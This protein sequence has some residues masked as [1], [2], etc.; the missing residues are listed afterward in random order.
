M[1]K[2]QIAVH[3]AVALGLGL[4][5]QAYAHVGS[6]A[7]PLPSAVG[8]HGTA[9][10]PAGT[11]LLFHRTSKENNDPHFLRP[12]C[13]KDADAKMV[14]GALYRG[15]HGHPG[16]PVK[17]APPAPGKGPAGAHR[18][19]AGSQ[20]DPL[21]SSVAAKGKP[22]IPGCPA[23]TQVLWHR[24]T[25]ANNDPKHLQPK[26]YPAAQIAALQHTAY[27][28]E[29]PGAQHKGSVQDPLPSA[30][31]AKGVPPHIACPQGWTG[32]YHR[33]T[34]PNNDPKFLRPACFN[35]ADLNAVHAVLYK[36]EMHK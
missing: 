35:H 4:A 6:I 13:F 5:S 23:G 15:E 21:A 22:P 7:D 11:H 3:L 29:K 27:R 10:C 24:T 28:G 30:V 20:Q 9:P 25:Q 16:A 17:G 1:M 18:G 34:Q 12:A 8:T 31:G 36:S 32:L 33:T 14:Q 26:C 2:K 19:H